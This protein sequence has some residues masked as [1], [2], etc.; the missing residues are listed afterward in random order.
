[1]N[2]PETLSA[3]SK[4]ATPALLQGL[5]LHLERQLELAESK[6]SSTEADADWAAA[7]CPVATV[8]CFTAG[9]SREARRELRAT[10]LPRIIDRRLGP[11]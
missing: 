4:Y 1:M 7:V 6:G 3:Q 5:V 9:S 8:L 2:T 10:L 11:G